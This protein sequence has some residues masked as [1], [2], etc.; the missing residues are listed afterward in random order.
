MN[1]TLYANNPYCP[2]KI[3]DTFRRQLRMNKKLILSLNGFSARQMKV[4]IFE[5]R[6]K[7]NAG[8]ISKIV[9]SNRAR[10]PAR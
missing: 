7:G 9:E 4:S 10:L 6:K 5:N 1:N 3:H 8:D 2:R